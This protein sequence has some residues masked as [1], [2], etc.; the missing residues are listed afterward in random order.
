MFLKIYITIMVILGI[1]LLVSISYSVKEQI[2]I[3]YERGLSEQMEN[4]FSFAYRQ[5][6]MDN[7]EGNH[8]SRQRL[9]EYM[10]KYKLNEK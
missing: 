3:A 6:A 8:M 1:A 2:D 4:T 9:G 7:A 5:G 10:G